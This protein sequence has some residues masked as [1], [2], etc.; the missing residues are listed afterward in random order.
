[1]KIIFKS[2]PPARKLRAYSR[3]VHA[4]RGGDVLG[5]LIQEIVPLEYLAV[6]F[7]ESVHRFA[8]KLAQ[9]Q[10]QYALLRTAGSEINNIILKRALNVL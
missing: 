6:R 7:A 4:E 3:A 10:R 2:L 9:L 1:M 5:L 8:R